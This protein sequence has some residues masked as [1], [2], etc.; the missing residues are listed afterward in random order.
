[1]IDI[2]C[3]GN[4]FYQVNMSCEMMN[5]IVMDDFIKPDTFIKFYFSDGT[6][7]FARKKDIQGFLDSDNTESLKE[8]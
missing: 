8:D 4:I 7:G 5:E 3:G 6:C 1:M 2:I